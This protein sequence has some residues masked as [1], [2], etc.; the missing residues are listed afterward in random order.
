MWVS[1]HF[2]LTIIEPFQACVQKM[3]EM[4]DSYS[5]SMKIEFQAVESF[6]D[7]RVEF[8]R[9]VTCL[10]RYFTICLE[11]SCKTF[12]DCQSQSQHLI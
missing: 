9:Y 12:V 2:I 10:V 4:K 6:E 1:K 8:T 7:K 5:E 11:T 3:D